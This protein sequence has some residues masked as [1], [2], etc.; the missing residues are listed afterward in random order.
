MT[1]PTKGNVLQTLAIVNDGIERND[2]NVFLIMLL[3]DG[4]VW[5]LTDTDREPKRIS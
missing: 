1:T 3:V 2:C 5:E 4:S